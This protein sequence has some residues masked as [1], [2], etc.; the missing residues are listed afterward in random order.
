VSGRPALD[1]RRAKALTRELERRAVA[2]LAGDG[3][4]MP[5]GRVATAM[6][7]I[8]ARIGEE[9]TQRL[10]AVPAKQ[11]DN[12]FTAMGLGRD[13]A[14]PARVPVAFKLADPAPA[15]TAAPRGTRLA[16]ETE[17]PPVMFETERGIVLA[18]G[19]ISTLAAVDAA[20]DAIFL[21][22]GGVAGG[23]LP[24][25]APPRRSVRGGAAA[26]AS[27]LQVSPASNLEAGTVLSLGT[28]EAARQYRVTAIE[29]ELITVEPPLDAAL[30]SGDRAVEVTDFAPF[31]G[32][33]RNRQFH[34]LYLGHE[35][36]LDVPSALSI[37]VA[38]AALPAATIWSWWG[39]TGEEDPA[40]WQPLE[41][42]DVNGRL[43]LE[44][45]K[46]NP[47]GHRRED[48]FMAARRAARD[49]HRIGRGARYP[50]RDRRC[51]SLPDSA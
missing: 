19:A 10:D 22:P 43:Q 28:G 31:G 39:K 51:G 50:D 35:T 49:L 21:S 38:G 25:T 12:F 40:A 29:G 8:A 33:S 23:A 45:K 27:Q 3:Q 44:K 18:P 4:T 32:A 15:D 9:V 13:P 6:L 26:G 20:T 14:R 16:A 5:V 48:I 37:T 1:P 46:G 24:R 34:A 7:G 41:R 2:T 42:T 11:E 30:A 17:G 47:Q 36:L